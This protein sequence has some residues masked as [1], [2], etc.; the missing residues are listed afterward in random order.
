MSRWEPPTRGWPDC[1]ESPGKRTAQG[2]GHPSVLP[3]LPPL[4]SETRGRKGRQHRR[5]S[6]EIQR[7]GVVWGRVSGHGTDAGE[8][9]GRSQRTTFMHHHH[10]EVL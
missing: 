2:S 8:G 10:L 6:G 7:H 3:P 5:L 1:T 9:V 4:R